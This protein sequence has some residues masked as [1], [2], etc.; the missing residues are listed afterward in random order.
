MR[1]KNC[2]FGQETIPLNK[3]DFGVVV[4]RNEESPNNGER[5]SENAACDAGK[6]KEPK[7]G[8]TNSYAG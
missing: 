5:M 1:C 3:Y 6:R 8:R 4:C 2:R 7:R